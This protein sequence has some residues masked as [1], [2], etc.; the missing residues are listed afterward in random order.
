[1]Y[2]ESLLSQTK[3]VFLFEYDLQ[4]PMSALLEFELELMKK[5]RKERIKDY[6]I[7]L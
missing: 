2:I 7:S 3:S 4:N 6:P 5:D 1:M